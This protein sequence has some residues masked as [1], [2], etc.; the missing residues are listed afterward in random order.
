MSALSCLE[1]NIL[2][3][4]LVLVWTFYNLNTSSTYVSVKYSSSVIEY[5]SKWLN[6]YVLKSAIG[7]IHPS[8]DPSP[9]EIVLEDFKSNTQT[10]CKS[11]V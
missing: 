6:L 10:V 11:I 5:I 8:N 1:S 3:I 7:D 9:P 4:C 2:C